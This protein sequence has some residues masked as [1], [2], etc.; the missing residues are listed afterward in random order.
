VNVYRLHRA[1]RAPADY[2]GAMLAGGRWN[3]IGAAMLYT[4][5]HLSL[6][7]LEILVHLDKSQLP[8]DYVW[9]RAE[10]RGDP[11]FLDVEKVTHVV[12]CQAAGLSWLRTSGQLAVQVPSVLIPEEFNVLLNPNHA[13]YAGLPWSEARPFRFDPRLFAS[14]PQTF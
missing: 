12:S 4:A 14:E 8:R 3:P 13:G 10:L 7:C 11:P 6:A 9:S 1:P 5:R 2:T